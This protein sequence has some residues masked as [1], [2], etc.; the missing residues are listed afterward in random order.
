[1]SGGRRA[2]T[3]ASRWGLPLLAGLASLAMAG[4][5]ANAQSI[6]FSVSA[7]ENIFGAGH[8]TAPGPGGAG[9]G[10]LPTRIDL[11]AGTGRTLVFSGVTGSIDFGGCCVANGPDGVDGAGTAAAIDWDGIGGLTISRGRFLGGVFLDDTEPADPAPPDLVIPDVGFSSLA[12]S[13]RQSF[14]VGDGLTGSGSGDQQVF[15]VPDGATRLFL[16]FHDAGPPDTSLPGYYGDN[17]GAVTGG[18]IV[19]G[20]APVPLASP[21]A[22]FAIVAAA[23]LMTTFMASR[24]QGAG[25]TV[26]ARHASESART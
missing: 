26:D 24:R 13:L 6:P 4:T 15:F 14:F 23:T 9:A 16:G 17:S 5:T 1:M 20:A 11:P 10:E 3:R 7:M 22:G 8:A 18:V 25:R 12:P 2:R 21:L 19:N